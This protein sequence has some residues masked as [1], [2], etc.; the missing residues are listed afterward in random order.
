M[1]RRKRIEITIETSQMLVIKSRR[2]SAQQRQ[3]QCPVCQAQ[4]LMPDQAAAVIGLSTRVIYRRVEAGQ[5]HFTETADGGLF[6]CLP[7]LLEWDVDG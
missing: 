7:S 6:V 5:L 4:M 2:L 1:Q 3:R